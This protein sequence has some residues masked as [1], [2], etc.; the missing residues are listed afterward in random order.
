MSVAEEPQP[1]RDQKT[2]I[3]GLLC[4]GERDIDVDLHW[5]GGNPRV[6]TFAFRFDRTTYAWPISRELVNQGIL[7][8]SGGLDVRMHPG[9]GDTVLLR[10]SNGGEQAPASVVLFDQTAIGAF[11]TD[12]YDQ[13]SEEQELADCL[14][15][16][17]EDLRLIGVYPNYFDGY[18]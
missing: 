8:G 10:L 4:Q 7:S 2:T 14:D 15:D 3:K 17:D 5:S 9:A 1:L 13:Y 11:L 12:T 18:S 16:M 6:I